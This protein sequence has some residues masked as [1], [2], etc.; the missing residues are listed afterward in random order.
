MG[1]SPPRPPTCPR[2]GCCCLALLL[3]P[4]VDQILDL[5]GELPRDLHPIVLA[6]AALATRLLDT[7]VQPARPEQLADDGQPPAGSGPR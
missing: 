1:H 2:W 7:S 3:D 6:E 4:L 5:L